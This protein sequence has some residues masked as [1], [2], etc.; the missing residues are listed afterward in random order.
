MGP[1]EGQISEF[2]GGIG[3]LSVCDESPQHLQQGC[4]W[5]KSVSDTVENGLCTAV[6]Q[7]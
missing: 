5:D 3:V 6:G 1:D 7:D 4:I 2:M